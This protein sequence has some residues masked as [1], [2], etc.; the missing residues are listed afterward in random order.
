[1]GRFHPTKALGRTI[2]GLVPGSGTEDAAVADER[3]GEASQ[4][5]RHTDSRN[6]ED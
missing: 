4:G 5:L 1:M 2:E 6:R 3:V